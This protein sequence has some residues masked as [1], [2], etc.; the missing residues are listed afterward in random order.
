MG[1]EKN[2]TVPRKSENGDN[3]FE[4]PDLIIKS[5]NMLGYS[6]V[7]EDKFSGKII[8]KK[9]LSSKFQGALCYD[10]AMT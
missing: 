7:I 5:F 9:I 6:C 10:R 1:D 4:F 3:E 8:S 2:E